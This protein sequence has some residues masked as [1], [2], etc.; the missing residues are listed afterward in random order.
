[1]THYYY[2]PMHYKIDTNA[3]SILS[4]GYKAAPLAL[5][6]S[7]LACCRGGLRG[8]PEAV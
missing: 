2:S 6:A 8:V 3:I 4:F 7:Y 1:M 5:E